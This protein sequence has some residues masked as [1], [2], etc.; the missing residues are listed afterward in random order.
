MKKKNFCHTAKI[1]MAWEREA[2]GV[3][4]WHVHTGMVWLLGQQ[5]LLSSTGNSTQCSVITYMG[6]ESEKEWICVL[7]N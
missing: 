5:D 6:K 4:D 2:L 7:Y 1:Y 3:W